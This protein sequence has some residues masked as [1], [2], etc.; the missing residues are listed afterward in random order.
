[1][2]NPEVQAAYKAVE[3]LQVM[4]AKWRRHAGSTRAQVAE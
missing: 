4:L 1:M 3:R 2:S